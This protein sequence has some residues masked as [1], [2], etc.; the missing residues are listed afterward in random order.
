MLKSETAAK[1]ARDT[2][3]KAIREYEK[4]CAACYREHSYGRAEHYA[5]M[6]GKC[7]AAYLADPY[8]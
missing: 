5:D 6:A 3:L 8:S 7:R 2:L 1:K 4:A